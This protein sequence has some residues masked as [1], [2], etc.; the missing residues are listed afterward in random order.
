M[1]CVHHVYTL[2]HTHTAKETTLSNFDKQ[3]MFTY[4]VQR[5]YTH[6][7]THT[8]TAKETTLS[9]FDSRRIHILWGGYD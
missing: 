6:T 4:R 2:T 1:Y 3:N 5:V 9:Q 8:H 7:D